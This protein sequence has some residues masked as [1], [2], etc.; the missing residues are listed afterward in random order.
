[1]PGWITDLFN[2]VDE[3]KA[4]S[5]G[6]IDE[7]FGGD[8]EEFSRQMTSLEVGY[9]AELEAVARLKRVRSSTAFTERND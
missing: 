4:T 3:L 8:S 2:F 7:L 9:H 1:L 6:L 5:V